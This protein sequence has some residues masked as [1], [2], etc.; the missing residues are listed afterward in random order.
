MDRAKSEEGEEMLD[1]TGLS[2]LKGKR[3]VLGNVSLTGKISGMGECPR[4]RRL[5]TTEETTTEV[6]TTTTA[7]KK[8][9]KFKIPNEIREMTTTTTKYRNPVRMRMLRKSVRKARRK[10]DD[11]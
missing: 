10:F 1:D 4:S 9:N 2:K 7:S 11:P 5:G 6:K 3:E 8:K